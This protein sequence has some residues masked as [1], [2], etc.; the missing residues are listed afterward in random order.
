M[1]LGATHTIVFTSNDFDKRVHIVRDTG[2]RHQYIVPYEDPVPVGEGKEAHEDDLNM[3]DVE[4]V[5]I[6][7]S[8][9]LSVDGWR[10]RLYIL[11]VLPRGSTPDLQFITMN[12]C[13]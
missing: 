13:M 4:N 12:F 11:E 8:T 7:E 6:V 1:K 5:S 10:R 2:E 9:V 3:E